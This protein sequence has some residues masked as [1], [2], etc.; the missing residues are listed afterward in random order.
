MKKFHHYKNYYVPCY[1]EHACPNGFQFDNPHGIENLSTVPNTVNEM[2]CMG[3]Q[4]VVRLFP[5]WNRA[6][7]ASFHQ[8]RVEGAFLVSAS[9]KNGEV[10]DLSIY[11]EQGRPLCLLNPWK[12]S[13]ISVIESTD[14]K[15]TGKY[16]HSG[17]R[18][19]MP[20]KPNTMYELRVKN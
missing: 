11:S 18:I 6:N 17:E 8:I 1:T 19:S 4:D 15:Q 12:N 9:M 14:G 16:E 13:S 5:V 20:T 2:L 7:D 10:T 3:H